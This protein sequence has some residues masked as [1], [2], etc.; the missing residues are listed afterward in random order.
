MLLASEPSLQPPFVSF[1]VLS[2]LFFALSSIFIA[3]I[4]KETNIPKTTGP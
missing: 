3:T 4:R 2:F 1:L